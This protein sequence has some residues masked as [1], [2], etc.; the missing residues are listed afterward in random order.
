MCVESGGGGGGL[1]GI[2]LARVYVVC[3]CSVNTY[4][5]VNLG[6]LHICGT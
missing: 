3:M 5:A 1:Y 2:G 6:C 4:T